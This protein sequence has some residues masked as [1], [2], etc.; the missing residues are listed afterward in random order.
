MSVRATNVYEE[1][2]LGVYN[3]E[4]DEQDGESSFDPNGGSRVTIW[5]RYLT[6]HARKQLSFGT[7][8]GLF[9]HTQRLNTN[10]RYV[11]DRPCTLP[12]LHHRSGS[13]ASLCT[14]KTNAHLQRAHLDDPETQSTF[15]IFS[16]SKWQV[17]HALACAHFA[18]VFELVSAYGT[19]GLS[20]GLSDVGD[21][22]FR[23]APNL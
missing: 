5:S 8:L 12:H 6:M 7:S 13:Y 3:P 11:V 18:A 14:S 10:P 21:R 1:Q 19:V 15:N 23:C 16:I 2:S 17:Y 4:D 20:L 9:V 22:R